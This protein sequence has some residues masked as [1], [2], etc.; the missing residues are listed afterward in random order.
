MRPVPITL[1]LLNIAQHLK[2]HFTVKK[3]RSTI[4]KRNARKRRVNP[5][6]VYGLFVKKKNGP[7]MHYIA[8]PKDAFTNNGRATRFTS[9]SA[10]QHCAQRLISKFHRVL[11]GYVFSIEPLSKHIK[12]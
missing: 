2:D 12:K 7:K 5:M 3:K 11:N 9:I 6:N 4:K 1:N 8:S 10:A